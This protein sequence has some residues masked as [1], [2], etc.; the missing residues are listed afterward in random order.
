MTSREVLDRI[1]WELTT[2]MGPLAPVI[3]RDKRAEFGVNTGDFPEVERQEGK[4]ER[5]QFPLSLLTN[6]PLYFHG[7]W[8]APKKK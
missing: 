1:Q 4:K 2:V 5:R 8:I 6:L 7:K 3:I